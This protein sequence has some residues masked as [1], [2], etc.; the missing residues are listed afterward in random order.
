MKVELH[1]SNPSAR[2]DWRRLSVIAPDGDGH[3]RRLR[4]A[5]VHARHRSRGLGAREGAAMTVTLEAC[6]RWTWPPA[7]PACA[8]CSPAEALDALVVTHLP[9]VR[10]LT[11]FTG[12][13]AMLVV[14]GDALDLHHRRPLPHAELRSSSARPGW[15]PRSRSAPPRPSNARSWRARVDA[16]AARRPRGPRG[17]LVV[18]ARLRGV[19][20]RS[21]AR[22][23]QRSGRGLASDQ[24]AG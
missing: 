14:T 3:H 12:S 11:G 13:A 16:D 4:P 22:R 17:E 19:V 8:T 20:R 5:R 23:H 7:R 10:Y 21:R 18:A 2:E 15:T 24:G 9:N 6:R 1:V